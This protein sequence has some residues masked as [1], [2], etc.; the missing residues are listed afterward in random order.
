MYDDGEDE[1][2]SLHKEVF[3]WAP[4]HL[5]HPVVSAQLKESNGLCS[6]HSMSAAE[7]HA[8]L[9]CDASG[10]ICCQHM[11]G[12]LGGYAR[13]SA[14]LHDREHLKAAQLYQKLPLQ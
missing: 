11:G 7:A 14:V 12:L 9:L 6:A 2:T 5:P 4:F 3:R 10:S 13:F 8:E 1:W